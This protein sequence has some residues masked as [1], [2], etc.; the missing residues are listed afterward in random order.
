MSDLD[1]AVAEISKAL[2]ELDVPHML[3]GGLAVAAWQVP[4]ATLDV[5]VCLWVDAS[6]MAEIAATL[7]NKLRCR[8]SDPTAFAAKTSVVPLE[9][10]KGVRI[11][12]IFGRLDYERRAIARAV[13]H[14]FARESVPVMAVEDLIYVKFASE[15]SKDVDDATKL[16]R[17][18][19]STLNRVYLE[20]LLVE[21]A[22]NM[23][24][25]NLKRL[26]RETFR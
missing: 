23:A 22:E 25:D 11:D 9:S 16:V 26:I 1:A 19:A 5:D 2:R 8:T 6:R 15:R 20:P 7:S 3:I 14:E 21:L 24:N 4:R 12:C 18:H 13:P 10:S 17:R